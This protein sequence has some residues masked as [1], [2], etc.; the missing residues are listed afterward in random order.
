MGVGT[1][2]NSEME[3]VVSNVCNDFDQKRKHFDVM[4]ADQDDIN[5]IS[6]IEGQLWKRKIV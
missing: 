5:V 1:I 4:I 2:S 6:R 3:A